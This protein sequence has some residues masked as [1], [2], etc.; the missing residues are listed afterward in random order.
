MVLESTEGVLREREPFLW[1][2]L[3][4]HRTHK[5]I[6]ITFQNY[7]YMKTLYTDKSDYIVVQKSTQCGVSEYLVIRAMYSLMLGRSVFYVMP[8]ES[9]RNLFVSDRFNRS[10]EYSPFYYDHFATLNKAETDNIGLKHFGKGSINFVGSV[11][12][13]PFFSYP[14]DELII[15]E[16]D[17]CDQSNIA[18]ADER[19]SASKCR[20][21]TKISNPTTL[22]FGIN[23]EYNLTDKKKW[24]LKCEHCG[25][26]VNP[27]FFRHVVREIDQGVFVIRDND[28]VTPNSEIKMICECGKPLNRFGVGQWIP[29]K[30]NM[31][32]SGYLISK[33]FST[34]TSLRELVDKFEEGL[35]ND[36]IMQRFYNGDLGVA[37]TS[38]GSKI[39]FEML[40]RCKR[41]YPQKRSSERYTIMGI[42]VGTVLHC[43]IAEVDSE[44]YAR[45]IWID[46]LN[47][48]NDV[49]EVA[50]RFN[51]RFGC[52]DALP[53]T[54]LSKKIA[55]GMRGFFMVYYGAAKKDT[56]D[57]KAKTIVVNRTESLDR[58]KESIVLESITFFNGIDRVGQ[59]AE[60]GYSEFYNQMTAS[61]RLYDEARNVYYWDEGSSDDHYFHSLNYLLIAKKLLIK[62]TK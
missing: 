60:N 25:K 51:V 50:K 49:I 6:P 31:I 28:A 30:P 47:D 5:D 19:L 23:H 7:L 20:Q 46:K 29:E 48:E 1:L 2:A 53:E 4:K 43:S 3:F 61:T 52:I 21:I 35:K 45:I 54:R 55:F 36:T 27:D 56:I 41:D 17:K 18:I 40:D 14:A 32:R 13:K 22:D 58:L 26:W 8:T 44:G 34:N 38:S 37:Y 11:S 59:L 15:D 12:S 24:Y 42:D 33:L 57:F 9:M 62:A 16:L 10:L 39:N